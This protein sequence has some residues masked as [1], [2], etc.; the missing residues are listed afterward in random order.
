MEAPCSRRKAATA[1]GV[2]STVPEPM[3]AATPF[4]AFLRHERHGCLS[5][6]VTRPAA[7][8]SIKHSIIPCGR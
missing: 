5:T 4:T 1:C 3:S 7:Y 2:F 8:Q 6:R